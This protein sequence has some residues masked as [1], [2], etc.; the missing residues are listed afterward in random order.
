M[1]GNHDECLS[2]SSVAEGEYDLKGIH[3]LENSEVVIESIKFYGSP[4]T[5][6]MFDMAFTFYPDEADKQWGGVPADTDVLITH[7]PMEG[8]LDDGCGCPELKK[9]VAKVKPKF[10]LFGHIHQAKGC[11]KIDGTQF[12]NAAETVNFFTI[13]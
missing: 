8:V 1:A 11:V 4:N 5:P 3:Y 13:T 7:G 10:H 12:S 2:K 6:S 9:R